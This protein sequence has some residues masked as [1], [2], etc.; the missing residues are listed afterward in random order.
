MNY[1]QKVNNIGIYGFT[2]YEKNVK[3]KYILICSG[4]GEMLVYS[5]I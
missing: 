4:N 1:I 5:I 3:E 2:Y